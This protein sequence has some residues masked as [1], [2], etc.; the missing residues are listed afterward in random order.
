[1]REFLDYL[2]D[3]KIFI[4]AFI[5]I[6]SFMALVSFFDRS[7]RLQNSN[8]LY[9]II[10][11]IILFIIFILV[12]FFIQARYYR[13]LKKVFLQN[14]KNWVINLPEPRNAL[15]KINQDLIMKLFN[16]KT[17]ELEEYKLKTMENIDFLT[18]WVH[19]I[20]NPIATIKLIIENDAQKNNNGIYSS[21][22]EETD[23]IEDFVQKVLY[24]ARL[25][26]FSQDYIIES[27]NLGNL[28]NERI[29]RFSRYFIEKKI[30]LKL[31]NLNISV[32]TDRKSLG[33]IIDQ[34]VS[35]AL[36]YTKN[37][38]FI[39][40]SAAS[41]ENKIVLSLEDNGAG[42]K[43]E[44]IGRVFNKSFTGTAG[45]LLY[46]STGL[47]LYLSINIA[48]KMNHQL[49]IKSEFGKGTTVSI[50]FPLKPEHYYKNVSIN[51]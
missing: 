47:G 38:G 10:V 12:D 30:K 31:F 48:K 34:V 3:K 18:A 23:K 33:F 41:F 43:S 24:Y 51:S 26:D 44:D 36:K 40:V 27:T 9:I 2:K 37:G 6:I 42:I 11:S 35:N 14:D 29:K 49:D 22:E 7:N 15:E 19:Q 32:L 5:T 39:K 20:K 13:N 45:R 46:N 21:I 17:I 25:N 16:E 28:V 50:H 1:M 8:L 4:I